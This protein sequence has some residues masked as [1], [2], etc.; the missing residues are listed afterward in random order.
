MDGVAPGP[1]GVRQEILDYLAE[2]VSAPA[3]R[4]AQEDVKLRDCGLDSFG[5]FEFLLG[6]EKRFGLTLSEQH[7]DVRRCRSVNGIVELVREVRAHGAGA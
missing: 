2:Y 6:L 1:D 5:T 3:V 4:S 7:L